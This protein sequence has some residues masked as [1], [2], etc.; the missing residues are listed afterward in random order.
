M[1]CV[2]GAQLLTLNNQYPL[3]EMVL[4]SNTGDPCNLNTTI[5]NVFKYQN[6][7]IT[8]KKS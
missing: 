6:Y 7:T 4:S 1:M 8:W 3:E 5:K 2:L